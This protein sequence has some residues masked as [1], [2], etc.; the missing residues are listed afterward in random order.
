MK[1]TATIVIPAD[2]LE[3]LNA[4]WFDIISEPLRLHCEAETWRNLR[5]VF[6]GELRALTLIDR[7]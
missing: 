3:Q 6:D 4:G 5:W 7:P 1:P 2:I